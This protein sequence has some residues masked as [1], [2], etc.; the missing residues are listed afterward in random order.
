MA[1]AAAVEDGVL[2]GELIDGYPFDEPVQRAIIVG[3]SRAGW[4]VGQ[5]SAWV[6]KTALLR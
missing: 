5:F 6:R 4:S 1:T 3:H 2:G